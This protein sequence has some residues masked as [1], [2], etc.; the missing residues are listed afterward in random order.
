M[1]SIDD[2]RAAVIDVGQLLPTFYL[3]Q[4]SSLLPT[5]GT[6]ANPFLKKNKRRE[7]AES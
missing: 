6:M 2:W 4:S 7:K 5:T 3:S 1:D